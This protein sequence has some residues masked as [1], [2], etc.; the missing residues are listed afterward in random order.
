MS[1][2]VPQFRDE[3]PTF[4]TSPTLDRSVLTELQQMC[5]PDTNLVEELISIFLADTPMQLLALQ[6][7]LRNANYVEVERQAHR[8][9]GSASAIGADRLREI[10]EQIEQ[11][12]RTGLV[13]APDSAAQWV[14][15]ELS[16]LRKALSEW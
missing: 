15:E 14:D 11:Y 2:S 12:A 9:K 4:L 6:D 7:A 1:N 13:P 3:L 16:A 5:G 8:L 10:C